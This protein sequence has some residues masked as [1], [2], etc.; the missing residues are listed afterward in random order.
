MTHHETISGLLSPIRD[1]G[2]LTHKYNTYFI[3]D[4]TSSYAMIPIDVYK[5]NIDFRM[6]SCQKGIMA[7][8][9]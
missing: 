8:A 2:A 9:G 4:T 7:M 6:S 5:D 1:V 3:I